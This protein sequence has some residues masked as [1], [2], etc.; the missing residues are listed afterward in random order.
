MKNASSRFRGPMSKGICENS[1]ALGTCQAKRNFT[2][3][4]RR[5]GGIL[6]AYVYGKVHPFRHW[7]LDWAVGTVHA[8]RRSYVAHKQ[9]AIVPADDELILARQSQERRRVHDKN[10]VRAMCSC[11]A[12][13]YVQMHCTYRAQDMHSNAGWQKECLFVGANLSTYS[14]VANNVWQQL[15]RNGSD[16]EIILSFCLLSFH[17]ICTLF[18]VTL[19]FYSPHR[20]KQPTFYFIVVHPFP[21]CSKQNVGLQS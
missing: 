13:G 3:R 17:Q 12:Q 21:N 15:E 18:I 20:E 14:S 10:L 2:P 6:W 8:R 7:A 1:K 11:N 16:T 9:S 19:A 5:G 4:L